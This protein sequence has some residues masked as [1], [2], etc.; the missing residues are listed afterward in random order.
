[1]AGTSITNV[2]ATSVTAV[3]PAHAAGAVNVV[4]TTSGGSVAHIG[5]FTYVAAPTTTTPTTTV[6]IASNNILG[7]AAG[8]PIL[9][10]TPPLL[11]IA[12]DIE[13]AVRGNRVTLAIQSPVLLNTAPVVRYRIVLRSGK[14]GLVNAK[15]ITVG[16]K[17]SIKFPKF[18]SLAVGTYRIQITATNTKGKQLKW[19]SPIVRIT[20]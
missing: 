17:G 9:I 13:L 8:T 2:S 5:G 11:R 18:T 20:G 3:T 19:T 6:P 10:N 4:L 16:A 15:T 1:M 7:S 12:A 14:G